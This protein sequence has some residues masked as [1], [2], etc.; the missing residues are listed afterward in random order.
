M[1]TQTDRDVLRL[2]EDLVAP[3]AAFA[4]R[5]RRFGAT[6][7]LAQVAHVL[8]VDEAHAGFDLRGDAVRAAEV[9][10]PHI[11]GQAVLNIVGDAHRV[12][13]VV[14]RNEAGDRA[15]DFFLR[16]PHVVAHIGEDG[17]RDIVSA[18]D[19]LWQVAQGGGIEAAAQ[20]GRAFLRP[21]LDIAAHLGQMRL[22]DHRPDDGLHRRVGRRL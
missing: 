3:G 4:P 19:T 17:R 8:A 20:Q 15:E 6:E 18:P 22:A 1:R 2:Q 16:N 13:L 14:E 12:G 7:R 21:Q 10:G 9:F 11:T 5:A